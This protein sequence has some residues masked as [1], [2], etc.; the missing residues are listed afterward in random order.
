M[1]Y[2]LTKDG[3]K[4]FNGTR[5]EVKQWIR[6]NQVKNYVLKERFIEKV[7]VTKEDAP[8]SEFVN[9]DEFIKEFVGDD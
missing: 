8:D 4:L 9:L 3:K 5:H 2:V 1:L 6:K 7:A